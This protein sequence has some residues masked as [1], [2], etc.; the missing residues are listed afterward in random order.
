[1][2]QR[3]VLVDY[4]FKYLKYHFLNAIVLQFDFLHFTVQFDGRKHSVPVVERVAH[5]VPWN[6]ELDLNDYYAEV[7]KKYY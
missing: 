1:M 6:A 4:H 5:S 7:D 3:V 2:K